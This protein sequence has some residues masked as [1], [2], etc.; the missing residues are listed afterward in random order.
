MTQEAPITNLKVWVGRSRTE[1]DV[2]VPSQAQAMAAVLDRDP[3]EFQQGTPLPDFWHWVYFRPAVPR[4]RL[5]DD[6]HEVRGDF[7]PPVELP[8]RMWAGGFLRFLSPITIGTEIERTSEVV[9]V[10]EKQGRSGALVLV[11]VRHVINSAGRPCVEE[12]QDL[13]YCEIPKAGQRSRQLQTLANNVKW[14]DTFLPDAVTLFRYSAL[15]FNAHRIHYDYPFTTQIE[16]YRGLVVHGPLTALLLLDAAKRHT[17]RNPTAYRYR[18]LAPLFS[19]EPITLAG[20]DAS[21]GRETEVWACGPGEAVSM[22][23][24]VTW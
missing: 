12:E 22:H 19:D 18:G 3:T 16:G 23:A 8:R 15:L 2:V 5:G 20:R 24:R 14:K 6:G 9:S 4:S 17:R 21:D 13:V 10:E 1:H 11:T 7:L